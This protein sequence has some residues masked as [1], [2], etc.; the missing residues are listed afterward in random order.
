MA[1]AKAVISINI[2][3]IIPNETQSFPH[4]TEVARLVI[5]DKLNGVKGIDT[6]I[7]KYK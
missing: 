7:N 1:N 4:P 3:E 2:I 5:L 6:I